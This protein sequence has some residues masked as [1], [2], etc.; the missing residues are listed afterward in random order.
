MKKIK[1]TQGKYALVDDEDFQWLNQY[2]WH[3]STHNYAETKVEGKNIYMHRLVNKTPVGSLT[4]HINRDTLDNRRMNLRIADK[5]INSINR[6]LQSNNTSGYKGISWQKRT[7][8]WEAY[9]WIRGVK[10]HLGR[11]NSVDEAAIARQKAE[12]VHHAI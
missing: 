11:F 4:D 7:S 12:R 8:K 5:R 9:I 6:G 2:R 10:I 3:I 1:L